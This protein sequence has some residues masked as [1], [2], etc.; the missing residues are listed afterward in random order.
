MD[1]D[2]I[3]VLLLSQLIYWHGKGKNGSPRYNAKDREGYFWLAKSAKEFEEETLLTSKQVRR[4]LQILADIGLIETKLMRYNGY[5]TTHIRFLHV[6][7][8][9]TVITVEDVLALQLIAPSDYAQKTNPIMPKG[10]IGI[11]PKGKYTTDTI[12]ETGQKLEPQIPTGFADKNLESPCKVK[13]E[14]D[15][16]KAEDVLKTFADK[17]KSGKA[18]GVGVNAMCLLW[19]KRVAAEY[20]G[21]QKDLT[22]KEAGQL[23]HVLQALGQAALPVLD[24]TIQHWSAFASAVAIDKG[25]TPAMEPSCGFFCQHWNI[26]ANLMADYN[27]KAKTKPGIT[28][29]TKVVAAQ[30]ASLGDNQVHEKKATVEDVQATL[31][32]LASIVAGN[33]NT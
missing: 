11:C 16:M 2:P 30:A 17:S 27:N 9:R 7:G 12:T 5:P 28:P 29:T 31:A 21:F 19:K 26:A 8:N 24:H 14:E 13:A 10:Q 18:I 6:Q 25:V 3:V 1:N 23:K 20:G 33:S 4:G 22:Q 32:A 15:P